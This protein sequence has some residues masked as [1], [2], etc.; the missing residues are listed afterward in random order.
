MKLSK[1]SGNAAVILAG[2]SGSRMRGTVADKVLEPLAGMPVIL[3]SFKAFLESG[4]VSEI[5]FVCRDE[6]QKR[7]I[8]AALKTF[9]PDCRRAISVKFARGGAHPP[10]CEIA[11]DG[12]AYPVRYYET[13]AL[14]PAAKHDKRQR[15]S[16]V[17]RSVRPDV[18]ETAA[19]S[20]SERPFKHEKY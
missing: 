15:T 6:K 9:F 4:Q 13:Y 5:V 2:G 16:V 19:Q 18:C 3:H 17:F 7:A 14:T 1:K 11:P 8:C 10:F 12:F 20:Q